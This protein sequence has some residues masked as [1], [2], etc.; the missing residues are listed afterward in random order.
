MQGQLLL[1]IAPS[2]VM[3]S[4]FTDKS[5]P[6]ICWGTQ[7]LYRVGIPSFS[8]LNMSKPFS[9]QRNTSAAFKTHLRSFAS[10]NHSSTF[11]GHADNMSKALCKPRPTFEC[12]VYTK[13]FDSA[14][15]TPGKPVYL[16]TNNT[17]RMRRNLAFYDFVFAP[18]FYCTVSRVLVF[19]SEFVMSWLPF[20]AIVSSQFFLLLACVSQ[21]L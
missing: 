10:I 13:H 11:T 19:F 16:F 8:L 5:C 18:F 4:T 3:G 9:K 1:H 14:F 7:R 17:L 12:V 21:L 20:F 6:C 2:P 15:Q